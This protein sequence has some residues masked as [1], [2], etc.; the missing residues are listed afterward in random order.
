MKKILVL[1]ILIFSFSL[2][3]S[4]FL[5]VGIEK[6][7]VLPDFELY[8]LN[9]NKQEIKDYLG[10]NIILN[11]WATWCPPCRKEMPSIEKLYNDTKDTDLLILAVSVDDSSTE[12]VSK[13]IKENNYTFKIFHD[14]K[15]ELGNKFLIRSIPTTYVIDKQGRIKDKVIGAIDWYEY[16]ENNLKGE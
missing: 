5:E 10:K 14:K 15:K 7:N 9:G 3:Y 11:F 6:G 16:Y 12:K 8:D 1:L 4:N 2:S 13:F